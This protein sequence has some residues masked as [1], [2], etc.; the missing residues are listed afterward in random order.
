MQADQHYC[1]NA[2]L[3]DFEAVCHNPRRRLNISAR[4]D[5]ADFRI[6]EMTMV[7]MIAFGGNSLLCRAALA[8][9]SIDPASFTSIRLGFGALVLWAVLFSK[10]SS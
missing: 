7:A 3:P 10:Q 6:I 5:S 1:F 2:E 9:T 4:T 8:H